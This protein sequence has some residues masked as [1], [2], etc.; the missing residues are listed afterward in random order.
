MQWFTASMW[1]AIK[2]ASG[3]ARWTARTSS[4]PM[5]IGSRPMNVAVAGIE[6]DDLRPVGC[7]CLFNM[8]V[9]DRVA[10]DVYALLRRVAEND[11]ADFAEARYRPEGGVGAVLPARLGEL[12]AV[13]LGRLGQ[14]ADVR[15]ACPSNL[16]GILLVLREDGQPF[17]QVRLGRIVPMVGMEMRDDHRVH[18]DDLRDGG[19]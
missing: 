18:I 14:D 16:S 9:P 19:G 7:D 15:E 10:R 3:A 8:P 2:V 13:E 11:S 12:D 5:R 6:H 1:L 17:L 4:S